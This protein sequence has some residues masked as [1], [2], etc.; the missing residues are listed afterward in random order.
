M[1]S[2]QIRLLLSGRRAPL[3]AV[4]AHE[5]PV[6]DPRTQLTL[7]KLLEDSAAFLCA[8]DLLRKIMDKPSNLL[9]VVPGFDLQGHRKGKANIDVWTKRSTTCVLA[10]HRVRAGECP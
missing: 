2:E 4:Q 3:S 9:E 5:P 10:L 7:Q 8:R 1:Q 6:A